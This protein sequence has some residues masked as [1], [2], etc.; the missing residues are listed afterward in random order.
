MKQI[1][2]KRP[3]IIFLVTSLLGI[4]AFFTYCIITGNGMSWVIMANNSD[5]TMTDFTRHLVFA[6][7]AEM[8]YKFG[9]IASFPPFC[10]LLFNLMYKINPSIDTYDYL[11]MQSEP[12]VIICYTMF[13]IF[14][15]I[16]L[17]YSI[18][19]NL[20]SR[21]LT[22]L[23]SFLIIFSLP[24]FAGGIERGNIAVLT[25][26]LC[27]IG[28]TFKDSDKKLLKIIGIVCLI[29]AVNIKLY[30]AIFGILYLYE[31]RFKEAI[32]FTI[33]SIILFFASSTFTGGTEG[34]KIYF[35]Y[36][37]EYSNNLFTEYMSFKSIGFFIANN[38]LH[39]RNYAISFSTIYMIASIIICFVMFFLTK[40]EDKWTRIFW[41]TFLVTYM[42]SQ[43]FRYMGCY[44][45]IPAIFLMKQYENG[46]SNE[47]L[48]E[49]IFIYIKFLIFGLYFTIPVWVIPNEPNMGMS[50]T[51]FIFSY[52]LIIKQIIQTINNLKRINK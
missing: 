20:K 46:F 36:L 35:G 17:I 2:E 21:E 3:Y 15:I 42:V 26:V 29:L 1:L 47:S 37:F 41:S 28:L 14:S 34:L 31:K 45:I 30:P 8:Y 19:I 49:K 4:L 48:S 13:I 10:V 44:M 51:I 6:K 43:S 16:L 32:S 23:T 25:S 9:S 33:G 50:L 39:L 11:S 7:N 52:I 18:S 38:I 40:K 24:F 12:F 5:W 27:L 22:F